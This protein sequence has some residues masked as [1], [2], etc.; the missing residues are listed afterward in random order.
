MEEMTGFCS[1]KLTHKTGDAKMRKIFKAGVLV[2]LVTLFFSADL[3]AED[4]QPSVSDAHAFISELVEKRIIS[5]FAEKFPSSTHTYKGAGQE[6]TS[7]FYAGTEGAYVSFNWREISDVRTGSNYVVVEGITYSY[8]HY[9]EDGWKQNIKDQAT[10]WVPDELTA[11]RLAK[12]MTLI[13]NA[14]ARKPKF[15]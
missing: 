2:A 15:D 8:S 4:A 9:E 11:K 10:F 3:L 7:W 6:C 5:A 14:C 12:A 13:K 1:D